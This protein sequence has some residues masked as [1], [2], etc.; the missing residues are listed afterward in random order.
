MEVSGLSPCSLFTLSTC[1]IWFNGFKNPLCQWLRELYSQL[2]KSLQILTHS[3]ACNV[4][5]IDLH[6]VDFGFGVMFPAHQR[7]I[8]CSIILKSLHSTCHYVTFLCVSFY[9]LS[10]LSLEYKLPVGR[11]FVHLMHRHIPSV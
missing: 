6:M 8:I 11:N 1:L 2:K 5:P 3:L 7:K 4:P 10:A 9:L